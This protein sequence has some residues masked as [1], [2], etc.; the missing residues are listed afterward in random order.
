MDA[1]QMF[2]LLFT[3]SAA[4]GLKSPRQT[5]EHTNE[6]FDHEKHEKTRNKKTASGHFRAFRVFRG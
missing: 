6:L 5:H 1:E 2:E 4:K 3:L